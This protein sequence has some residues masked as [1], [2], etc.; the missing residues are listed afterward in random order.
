M[1]S[2]AVAPWCDDLVLFPA[3]QNGTFLVVGGDLPGFE[4]EPLVLLPDREA[5]GEVV[6]RSAGIA[7]V[8]AQAAQA[9]TPARGLVRLAPETLNAMQAG[10]Q[11][12]S[13]G[14]WDLGSLTRE[15]KIVQQVRRPPDR[16]DT[17]VGDYASVLEAP[18]SAR[19]VVPRTDL[20]R[21]VRPHPHPPAQVRT[22]TA[23]HPPGVVGMVPRSA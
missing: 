3:D 4:L 15:G 9:L 19:R 12:L 6:A 8:G 21:P 20:C 22:V 16:L 1:T 11:P 18:C 5:I 14:G 23:R 2:V 17:H 10:A 7:N 13:S